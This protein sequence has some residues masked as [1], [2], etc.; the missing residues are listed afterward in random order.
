VSLQFAQIGLY[1]RVILVL[2]GSCGLAGL[3]LEYGTYP[4]PGTLHLARVLSTAA[5]GL[6]LTEQVMAWREAVTFRLYLR[7]R[8]PTF[9]LSALLLL[10]MVA[11][12]L[13]QRMGWLR[14]LLANLSLGSVT[15][16]YLIVVQ[17]YLLAVF[18]V[19][20]PHLHRRFASL[21]IRPAVAFV[22]LF[23]VL[24][25]V[26]AG[27]LMLPRSTPPTAPLAPLDA[28]FTSTS[29]VCVTGLIVRDTATGFTTFGQTVILVLIQLGGIGIMSL[30]AALSLLLGRGI[31]V[32]E[33]SLLREVF[34]VPMLGEVGRMVRTII[35]MTLVFEAAGAALLY[36][37][38][39]DTIAPV[40]P[41]LYAAVFHAVSAFC[42]AG[43]STFSDSLMAQARQPLVMGPV[44]GLL[45]VGGLGFGVV[46]QVMAWARGRM[47]RRH[48]RDYRLGL[49]GQIV[50]GVS[51][52]LLLT[53]TALL[54]LLEWNHALAG[55]SPGL[56]L[57]QAF[58][59]SATCR[60]A[61]FNSLDLNS[62]GS[63]SLL[64]MI[65]LMFI[66]G[67]PGSTAGGVKVTAVAIVWANLRSI[68]MG[69]TRVRLRRRE[70][71][72]VHV[73]RAMLVL[74]AG[75]VAAA[76]ALFVLLATEGRGFAETAFE[77]FSALGTVGLSLGLTPELSEVGRIVVILLMFLG[78]L[79]PLTLASSLTGASREPAA[80]RGCGCRGGASSSA[81]RPP[82]RM[83]APPGALRKESAMLKAAVIG[84]GKFGSAIAGAL[85]KGGAE[86][87]AIDRNS[88]LVETV[89]DDVAVAV[90]FDAT[91]LSNLRAYEVG[92]MDV[93]VVA[94]GENFEASVLVTMHCKALGVP[95]VYAKGLNDMQEAV[96]RRVGADSV[97][98]PEEDMGR[99]LADH[100]LHDSVVDFV[101]L[102]EGFSLR[103]IVVPAAWDG[104]S[105]AEL[106]LL[107]TMRL[108]LVQIIRRTPAADSDEPPEVTKIALPSGGQVLH[109]GDEIDV[110]GPD[111]ELVK[112][113]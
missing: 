26:G 101:Q 12:G 62:L 52:L 79:G 84:L 99:R 32:R 50:L 16:A 30:T 103:R 47:L 75:L 87:L 106:N 81:E 51:G 57:A 53:G 33:S 80:S 18:A 86:V 60:T 45:I 3:L 38:L 54:A 2:A 67:A 31:G 73:Q 109:A 27:L 113:T 7:R 9:L 28:L 91:D 1:R 64:L 20:L 40:G 93:V 37:G 110:I 61:G 10:E 19:E 82:G 21:R 107:G 44:A 66:G 63:A 34:Q 42:N 5:V 89:A 100:L 49:H 59:Q 72:A 24:I 4:G 23:A 90:G 88:R 17:I 69:L 98:K 46:V 22:T 36:V 97:I 95:Q 112:L 6:F 11:L 68:A 58:F 78:R 25:V 56:K 96:L 105:L 102:P 111:R 65:V 35:V 43:F 108:N 55:Q 14:G 29:A 8:W 76:C 41:R 70:L 15:R 71:E 104:K 77:V 13:G 39:R 83:T 94:I 92:S 48:G 85:S 74:S